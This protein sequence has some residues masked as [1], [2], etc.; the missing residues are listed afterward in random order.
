MQRLASQLKLKKEEP[1]SMATTLKVFGE[2]LDDRYRPTQTDVIL[3]RLALIIE[4]EAAIYDARQRFNE[5][6]AA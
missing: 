2:T 6:Q 5:L 4:M 1:A 3:E